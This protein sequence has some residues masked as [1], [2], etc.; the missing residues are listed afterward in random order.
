MQGDALPRD[1]SAWN[2]RTQNDLWASLELRR[3]A[4]VLRHQIGLWVSRQWAA[5][6]TREY[7]AR[8]PVKVVDHGEGFN[9]K[10]LRPGSV[11]RTE[12]RILFAFDPSRK[13]I[14]LFA[15]DKAG[16]WKGWCKKAVPIADDRFDEHLLAR[17]QMTTKVKK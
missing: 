3:Q 15:G 2:S 7:I 16:D 17:E 8:Q 13:A 14:V 9:M 1:S 6:L 10:E 11:G 12:V 4:A 5:K